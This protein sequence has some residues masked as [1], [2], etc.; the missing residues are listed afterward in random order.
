MHFSRRS[1]QNALQNEITSR[2]W[3]ISVH[4]V[5]FR[6]WFLGLGA[7]SRYKGHMG[8]PQIHVPEEGCVFELTIR[9]IG[10]MFLLT[11]SP[12]LDALM[13]GVIG[14]AQFLYGV[15]MYSY[16]ILSNHITLLVRFE[17]A[18]QAARF[19]CHLFTNI[20]KEVKRFYK[21]PGIV[22]HRRCRQI[23]CIDSGAEVARLKYVLS[24]GC[25]EGLVE[26]P[27]AWP[28]VHSSRAM[29]S[30]EPDV[31]VWVDW[32]RLRRL[33]RAKKNVVVPESEAETLY[34]VVLTPIPAWEALAESD[35]R[36][37][38]LQM[39]REIEQE[40]RAARKG[41]PFLGPEA[42]L[43][44][45]PFG[46]PKEPKKEPAPLCHATSTESKIS[47]RVAYRKRQEAYRYALNELQT[48]GRFVGLP[49]GTL[50]PG[51]LQMAA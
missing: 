4:D 47:Y 17:T 30:G 32:T 37:Q 21:V 35:R 46:S 14:R 39:I 28:G 26:S 31:G 12:R 2:G 44:Q 23:P 42:I 8:R 19:K 34:P 40:A 48:R 10:A 9:C 22:F 33:R 18:E 45:D 6:F 36:E 29:I 43:R 41:R 16:A 25:K 50:L 7:H 27:L 13:L 3:G 51:A 11:P 49:I 38:G 5:G 15:I 20:S 1:F 24:N